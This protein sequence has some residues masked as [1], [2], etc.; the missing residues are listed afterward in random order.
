MRNRQPT[1]RVDEG[2]WGT[3]D[4]DEKTKNTTQWGLIGA[5]SYKGFPATKEVLPSGVYSVTLD[6]N[7]DRPVFTRCDIKTDDIFELGDPLLENTVKEVR[8]FWLL[9]DRFRSYG[10]LHRRGYLFYGP[11]G[12]GKSSVVKQLMQDVIATNGIVL[13]CDNPK[14]FDMGL[15]ALRQAEPTRRVM[16]VFEDIDT[17]IARYGEDDLLAIL[18]GA[19]MIDVVLNVATTNYPEKLDRRIVSRPR[20]FDRV[21]K[22]DVP[23]A[24]VRK[25]FFQ[26]QVPKITAKKLDALV[27]NS[28]GLSLAALAEVVI[29]TYCLG[30]TVEQTLQILKA[31][32]ARDPSSDEFGKKKGFGFAADFGKDDEDNEIGD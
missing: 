20:R 21:V 9:G 24:P 30:N 29:S 2:V 3:E 32:E 12:T 6:R 28:E 16:C 14:F 31:M 1:A 25:A 10:F 18:D 15:V 4:L 7:D 17:I 5:R 23:S 8:D 19:N 27:K 26:K 13:L 11:Q 22:V